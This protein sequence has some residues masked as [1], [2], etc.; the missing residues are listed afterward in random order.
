VKINNTSAPFFQDPAND[1]ALKESQLF[2]L[3]FEPLVLLRSSVRLA[4][5]IIAFGERDDVK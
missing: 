5:I 1:D 3:R 2:R 4:G